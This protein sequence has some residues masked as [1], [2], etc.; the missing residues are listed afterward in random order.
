MRK[1]KAKTFDCVAMKHH[2]AAEV[3]RRT[4]GMSLAAELAFWRR[5]TQALRREQQ[6]ARGRKK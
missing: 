1:T 4:K 2:G 5:E 3:Y 6:V